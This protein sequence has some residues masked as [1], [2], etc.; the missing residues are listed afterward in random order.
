[1]K[2]CA[3]IFVLAHPPRRDEVADPLSL[4]A[5]V[6]TEEPFGL[7]VDERDPS[8]AVRGKKAFANPVQHR[9]A[10]LEQTEDVARL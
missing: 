5:R 6:E 1:M 4:S 3:A 7:V 8:V 2:R 9:L 10:L